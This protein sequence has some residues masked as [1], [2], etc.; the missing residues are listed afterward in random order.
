MAN[1][2]PLIVDTADGNKFK[3]LP[4]GDNLDLSGSGIVNASSIEVNGNLDVQSLTVNQQTLSAVAVS[5]DYND[6]NNVPVSFSGSYND[7]SNK[8]TIPTTTKNLTDVSITDPTDGQILV[9]NGTAGKFEPKDQT[10]IDLSGSSINDLQDV[11]TTGVT[12]LKYLKY[13]S[14]AWRPGNINYSEILNRP[15]NISSFVNDSG[16]LTPQ[17]FAAGPDPIQIDATT[18]FTGQ[19]VHQGIEA[20]DSRVDF[21]G[22]VYVNNQALQTPGSFDVFAGTAQIEGDG[23]L[24]LSAPNGDLVISGIGFN[25]TDGGG[26]SSISDATELNITGAVSFT[27]AIVT[28][29][30]LL[31]ETLEAGAFKGNVVGTNLGEDLLLDV[32]AQEAYLN[33]VTT[34]SLSVGQGTA[35]ASAIGQ[36]GDTAGD[37]IIGPDVGAQ[38]YLYYCGSDYDGASAIWYRVAMTNN[39]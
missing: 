5:G 34:D 17:Y 14:G 37:I 20:F 6:L 26:G 12:E 3:E 1:R 32:S 2:F 18:I 19:N 15:S 8:P 24:L 33:K 38:R 22:N 9:F 35:P 11:I 29:F 25:I 30:R 13:Q 16:Y 28:D 7:L 4:L 23:A 36:A 21:N 10:D 27:G 31:G 39:W